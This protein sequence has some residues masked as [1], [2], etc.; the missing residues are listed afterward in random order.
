MGAVK[1]GGVLLGEL[2]LG[3]WKL[4]VLDIVADVP[5]VVHAAFSGQR[6]SV[7]LR[8]LPHRLRLAAVEA[9]PHIASLAVHPHWK[10]QRRSLLGSLLNSGVQI[11][12]E[13]LGCE[14]FRSD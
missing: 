13:L 5:V 12:P 4:P 3:D 10:L 2:L 8:L 7:G 6:L 14:H 9:Q 11:H 1:Y